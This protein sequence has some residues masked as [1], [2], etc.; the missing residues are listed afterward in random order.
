MTINKSV[1]SDCSQHSS[2]DFKDLLLCLCG[3][4][5][6]CLDVLY[7]WGLGGCMGM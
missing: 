4:G 2:F 1:E 7:V 5:G 3:W 6:V